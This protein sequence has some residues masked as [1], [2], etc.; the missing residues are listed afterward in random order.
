MWQNWVGVPICIFREI[1]LCEKMTE[2]THG[3]QT[4]NP[5]S[6]FPFNNYAPRV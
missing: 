1:H 5:I 6:A 4:T 3:H 2:T